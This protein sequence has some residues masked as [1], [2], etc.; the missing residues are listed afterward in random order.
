MKWVMFRAV[1][2]KRSWEGV[3][4]EICLS[5]VFVRSI[6]GFLVPVSR[7][8]NRKLKSFL[9]YDIRIYRLV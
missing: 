1:R 8:V 5:R 4:C 7:L 9:N 2:R 6:D 3:G